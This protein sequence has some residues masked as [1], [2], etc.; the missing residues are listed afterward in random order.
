MSQRLHAE[1]LLD[2][3]PSFRRDRHGARA[4]NPAHPAQG[5]AA[6]A[7]GSAH[8]SCDVRTALAPIQA[9]AA[10]YPAAALSRAPFSGVQVHA[11]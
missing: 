8:G 9:G 4:L 3:L 2:P 11:E 1:R 10:E 6:L 5:K 7:Q